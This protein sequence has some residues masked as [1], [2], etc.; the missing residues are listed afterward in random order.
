MIIGAILFISLIEAT[1]LFKII[2][3]NRTTNADIEKVSIKIPILQKIV[4]SFIAFIII[5]IGIN[6]YILLTISQNVAESLLGVSNV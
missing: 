1:Y 5:Y 3:L 6:P 4:L 2:S